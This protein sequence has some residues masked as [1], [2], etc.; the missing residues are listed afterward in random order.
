MAKFG[1]GAGVKL[2]P[3]ERSDSSSMDRGELERLAE[4]SDDF[5]DFAA[6]VLPRS[7]RSS[8]KI[9][10]SCTITSGSWKSCSAR[11][12]W[13]RKYSFP[14]KKEAGSTCFYIISTFRIV[15][16]CSY[17]RRSSASLDS[18]IGGQKGCSSD[19]LLKKERKAT[20]QATVGRRTQQH[21]LRT[22]DLRDI[23]ARRGS[24]EFEAE[25]TSWDL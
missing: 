3:K 17:P 7:S 2:P 25:D 15:T 24:D 10:R 5:T 11:N 12:F 6:E 19:K 20:M 22:T 18:K 1:A 8:E 23:A 21:E 9:T 13:S 14:I 4:Q 16:G